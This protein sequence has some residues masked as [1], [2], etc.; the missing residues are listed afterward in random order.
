MSLTIQ[1]SHFSQEQLIPFGNRILF[2]KRE[3]KKGI[4]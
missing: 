1:T 4:L 3:K 2:K